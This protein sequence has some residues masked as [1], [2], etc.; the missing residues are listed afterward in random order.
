MSEISIKPTINATM[1]SVLSESGVTRNGANGGDKEK[2]CKGFESYF[3]LTMLKELQKTTELSKKK[4]Y[5]EDEDRP[6]TNAA[7]DEPELALV[8][9]D[10]ESPDDAGVSQRLLGS[11]VDAFGELAMEITRADTKG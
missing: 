3:M 9:F 1:A 8:R 4:G 2:V 7:H 11:V 5:M 10:P 6:C